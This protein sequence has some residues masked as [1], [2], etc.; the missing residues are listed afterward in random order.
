[1]NKYRGI[2]TLEVLEGAENYNK[3]I[4]SRI[5]PYVK[6]PALE[7]GAGTGNISEHMTNLKDLVLTDIDKNLVDSLEQ[8]FAKYKN[9]KV[10]VFNASTNISKVK[11]KF[12]S[13]YGVNVLEHIE[14]DEKTLRNLYELLDKTGKLVLLVP[15]KKLAYNEL[16]R[17]L[18]HFRRYEKDELTEK[19]K[20]AGFKVEEIEYFNM[21][22]LLSWIIRNYISKNH[23]KLEKSQVKSFNWVA[24]ILKAVEPKRGL[25]FGISLIAVASKK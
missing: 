23:G 16:D 9:V 1:M 19:I 18:G 3:W 25:P 20:N 6:S 14:N 4:A 7:I 2:Q 22:G 24:P 12:K 10:E 5:K 21:V 15:A 17:S 13:I 11:H 8:K